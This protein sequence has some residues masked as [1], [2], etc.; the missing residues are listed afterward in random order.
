VAGFTLAAADSLDWGAEMAPIEKM[1]DGQ[2]L[3]LGWLPLDEGIQ[4]PTVGWRRRGVVEEEMQPGLN[5]W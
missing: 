2:V 5:V 3:G 4:Q 1:R